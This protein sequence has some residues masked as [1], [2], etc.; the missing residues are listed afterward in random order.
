MV[1]GVLGG[2]VFFQLAGAVGGHSVDPHFQGDHELGQ[3]FAID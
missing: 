2:V 1:S 3:L